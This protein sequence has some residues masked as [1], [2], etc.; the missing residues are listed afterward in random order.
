MPD[1]TRAGN[2]PHQEHQLHP[3]SCFAKHGQRCAEQERNG[4]RRVSAI[5][6]ATVTMGPLLKQ[7]MVSVIGRSSD[8]PTTFRPHRYL[9]RPH[10][11]QITPREAV[12]SRTV[13]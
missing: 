4:R 10:S 5:G 6:A 11:W 8:S 1:E 9:V 3:R 7:R 13:T 12:S 2:N